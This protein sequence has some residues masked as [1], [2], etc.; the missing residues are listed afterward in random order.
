M[1]AS[2]G[3]VSSSM[4]RPNSGTP[5]STRT[6]SAVRFVELV[7]AGRH[8]RRLQRAGLRALHEEVESRLAGVGNARDDR[9]AA[10]PLAPRVAV[11]GHPA[12]RRLGDTADD[13][14]HLD[15][16]VRADDR[17]LRERVGD[18]A[19][20]HVLREDELIELRHHA[21]FHAAAHRQQQDVAEL[22]GVEVRDHASLRRQIRGVAALPRLQ[23]DDVVGQQALEIRRALG[24]GDD[25]PAAIGT[26]DERRAM[27][28]RVVCRA[29]KRPESWCYAEACPRPILS[30]RRSRRRCS[31]CR[32]GRP[33]SRRRHRC[34]CRKRAPPTSRSSSAAGRSG[35]NRSR[36]PA[37]PAAGPSS[38]PDVWAR[39]STPSRGGCRCA[40]PPTGNRSSF[41]LDGTVRGQ[42]Q[43][44][45]TTV[46]GTTATSDG[47][48]A[49]QPMQKT[50]TI[51]PNAL[52]V[53][54]TN[55]FGPYEAVA[56][57]LKTAAVGSEIPVYIVPQM[58][59]RIAVGESSAEQIQTTARLVRARRTRIA[60]LLPA[61]RLDADLWTDDTGRMI[62]FS[63]PLQSVEV[64]REDIAAVSSRSV[65]ISR[66]ND[67]QINIPSNG[68]SLAGTLSRPAQSTHDAAAGGRARRRQR[69]DRSRQPR[70]RHPDFRAD[71]RCARQRRLHRRPLRQAGHRSERRPRGSRDADRLRRRRARGG[72]A[73]GGS[74]G[75]RSQAHRGRSATAK[76][77]SSR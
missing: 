71:R 18:V 69:P 19:E 54:P 10:R 47:T 58:S 77:A 25:N 40:T 28:G 22:V 11:F 3:I 46:D 55:F 23:R 64:V 62:R 75:R 9:R 34:H 24:A 42:A 26:I 66:P 4:S 12:Q 8:Q 14:R 56:A 33:R 67:Q 68:F 7:D 70:R 72:E 51:D 57:R 44:I 5:D 41:T 6:A 21:V 63:V 38:A 36:S 45:H 49:G 2:S 76:A 61:G 15:G 73:A 43:T 17:D 1:P 52:L 27:A 65:T 59:I 37:S 50:D 29:E 39:R 13:R 74:Q 53:L 32:S 16:R 35:P 20:L 31:P 60:I 48:A 30:V